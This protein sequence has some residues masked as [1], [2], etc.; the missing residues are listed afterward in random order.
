MCGL[1]L[2]WA[3]YAVVRDGGDSGRAILFGARAL[4]SCELTLKWNVP[5]DRGN[6]CHVT[7]INWAIC[8]VCTHS[9]T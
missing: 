1:A 5:L 4:L 3:D 7:S 2:D 6:P 8:H 9:P